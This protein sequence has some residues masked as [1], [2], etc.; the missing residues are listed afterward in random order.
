M[1]E[2]SQIE[3]YVNAGDDE[4]NTSLLQML[5]AVDLDDLVQRT[6]QAA[7]I[8]ESVMLTL[9]ITDD[10]SI[11]DLNKQYREQE[12][13]TDVLSF[14]LLSTPLVQA[15][16]ELL[17]QP[18]EDSTHQEDTSE[19]SQV[20][21]FVDPPDQALNLGDIIVSWPTIQKQA[22]EANHTPIYELL[23]L[24]AH[25]ILHL[26]GY[27][28]QTEAGYQQMVKLQNDVLKEMGQ[29]PRAK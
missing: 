17:W 18:R 21:N 15:P 7:Q 29:S 10:E 27:D 8:Q 4:L 28:D 26:V 25:G 13:P 6:L 3:L 19:A 2:H 22:S 5:A 16:A 23:Y 24:V 1:Q 9:L 14:P 20:P 11:R 12:K